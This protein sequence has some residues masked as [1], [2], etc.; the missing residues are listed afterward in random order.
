MDEGVGSFQEFKR[1]FDNLFEIEPAG[2]II[3][4]SKFNFKNLYPWT[5]ASKY[6]KLFRKKK[7]HI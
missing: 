6:N 4:R 7:I 2:I 5:Q 3:F 1:L